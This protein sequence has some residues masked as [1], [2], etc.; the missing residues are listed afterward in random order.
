MNYEQFTHTIDNK[1]Q[2]IFLVNMTK[3][4]QPYFSQLCEKAITK[5]IKDKKNITI[6]VNKK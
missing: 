5:Y 3:E 6:I 4:I 2:K 1:T